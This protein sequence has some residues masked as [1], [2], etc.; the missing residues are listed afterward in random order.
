M[1]LGC[2]LAFLMPFFESLQLAWWDVFTGLVRTSVLRTSSGLSKATH[3]LW[4]ALPLLTRQLLINL[5]FVCMERCCPY[6]AYLPPRAAKLWRELC[7]AFVFP[8]GCSQ[9]WTELVRIFDLHCVIADLTANEQHFV[10]RLEAPTWSR[11]LQ[12]LEDEAQRS[13]S[14][15][16]ITGVLYGPDARNVQTRAAMKSLLMAADPGGATTEGGMIHAMSRAAMTCYRCGQL[17][18]VARDCTMPPLSQ[19]QFAA[20]G[21]G[22]LLRAGRAAVPRE[23]L[24]ALAQRSEQEMLEFDDYATRADMAYLNSR[25]DALVTSSA[26][27]GTT[28]SQMTT[29][30][31]RLLHPP[32]IV[33]G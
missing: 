2:S 8:Q 12:I 31:P 18:H 1:I 10:K 24:N 3:L 4:L 22:A 27:A 26:T 30:P 20:G 28:L 14:W 7:N 9:G 32:L 29:L 23:G 13:T 25:L 5:H 33:R 21:G 17:G 15:R 19:P 11:F 16:W 6:C